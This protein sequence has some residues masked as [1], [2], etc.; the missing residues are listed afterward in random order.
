MDSMFGSC[1]SLINL[2]LSNFISDNVINMSY[3][4]SNCYSLINLDI[5]H[6]KFKKETNMTHMFY[7][8]SEILINQVKKQNKNL[9]I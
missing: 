3:M 2:D 8:C 6:F 9:K 4:F 7:K 1:S 5:G